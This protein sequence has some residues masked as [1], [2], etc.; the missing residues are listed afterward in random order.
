MVKSK[1]VREVVELVVEFSVVELVNGFIVM[2]DNKVKKWKWDVEEDVVED[3]VVVG[4][5]KKSKKEK[6]EKKDKKDKKDKKSKK[7]DK[8]SCKEKKDKCKNL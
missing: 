8:E 1:C 3:D 2:Y 7:Y 5:K 6:K 4:E